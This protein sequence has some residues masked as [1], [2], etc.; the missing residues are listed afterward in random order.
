[1]LQ[2]T[3][4]GEYLQV[5]RLHEDGKSARKNLNAILTGASDWFYAFIESDVRKGVG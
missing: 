2:V 1:V 3:G 4:S 5:K